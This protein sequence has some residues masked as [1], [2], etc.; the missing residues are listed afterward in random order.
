MLNTDAQGVWSRNDLTWMSTHPILTLY[1]KSVWIKLATYTMACHP[2]ERRNR[3]TFLEIK[4]VTEEENNHQLKK[5]LR[6]LKILDFLKQCEYTEEGGEQQSYY[7]L[8]IPR[9]RQ[10]FARY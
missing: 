1:E 2:P 7:L 10:A 4:Q 6:I 3:F 8:H 9:A 5:A